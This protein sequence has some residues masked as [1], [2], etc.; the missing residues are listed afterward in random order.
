M[1]NQV[2]ALAAEG[3]TN[4]Q[5]A[6][7]LFVR[8]TVKVHLSHI[9]TK[10]GVATRAELASGGDQARRRTLRRLS[11]ARSPTVELEHGERVPDL[12][13]AC[14]CVGRRPADQEVLF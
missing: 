6:E 3:L 2:V 14:R 13:N 10:L 7:R 11:A 9:F 4:P 8:G 5:I 12:L 1:E